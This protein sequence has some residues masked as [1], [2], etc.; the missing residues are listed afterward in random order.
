MTSR[1]SI[2]PAVAFVAFLTMTPWAVARGQTPCA[3]SLASPLPVPVAGQLGEI[4]IDDNCE[5]VYVTNTSYNE[6]EVFSLANGTLDD[7]IGVGSLPVGIDASVDGKF[8][9]VANSGGNNI[10]IVDLALGVEAKKFSIPAGFLND[11]PLSLA[12]ASNGLIFLSTTFAGSGFGGRMLQVDLG[13]GKVTQRGDFFINGM[14]TEETYLRASGDRSAIGVVAGDISSAPVFEYRAGTDSF[15]G[16]KDLEG[17]IS[18]IAL[19]QTGAVAL[20]SPGTYV[21]DSD[22]SLSGTIPGGQWGVAVDPAGTIGYRVS[23]TDFDVG[24][25][26]ID[27]LNLSRFLKTGTLDMGTT[28]AAGSPPVMGGVGRMAISRDGAL[29]AVITDGG[30]SLVQTGTYTSTTTSTSSTS[31]PTTSTTTTTS[32][33]APTTSSTMTPQTSST[34]TFSSTTTTVPCA[35]ARCTVDGA[36]TSSPCAGETVPAG[37]ARKLDGATELIEQTAARPGRRGR[38]LLKHA[39]TMLKAAEAG[40][41]RAASGR[42]PKLTPECAEAL[43]SAAA[44]ILAGL[45]F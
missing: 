39:V 9:Y 18:L 37:I 6:V 11:T 38:R 27:V 1:S 3:S 40:A 19:D 34:T 5:H 14:T 7:P 24:T 15:T 25:S 45:G 28:V 13:A 33:T 29:L 23:P 2:F 4:L 31:L 32:T 20:V 41:G 43:R 22:L 36:L 30:F 44:V 16:E 12:V 10:S 21:L 17:F 8:L 26:T 35:N 42:R